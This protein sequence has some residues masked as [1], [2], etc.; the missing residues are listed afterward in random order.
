[1]LMYCCYV[2]YFRFPFHTSKGCQGTVDDMCLQDMVQLSGCPACSRLSSCV[3][4]VWKSRM[5][6]SIYQYILVYTNI[7]LDILLC[8]N[9]S[10]Y[11]YTLVYTSISLDILL[12]ILLFRIWQRCATVYR[13]RLTGNVDKRK[14]YL[15]CRARTHVSGCQLSCS[16]CCFLWYAMIYHQYH[17]IA[18]HSL[19]CQ[20]ISQYIGFATGKL[21]TWYIGLQRFGSTYE[22]AFSHMR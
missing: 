4:F 9:T 20:G 15:I 21:T 10:I 1:M 5:N 18:S 14:C 17:V 22:I 16:K 12:F 3:S 7:Y 11:Q 2:I 13:M 8:M 19:V 6:T